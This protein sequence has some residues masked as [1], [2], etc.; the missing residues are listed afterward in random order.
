METTSC[1]LSGYE[2]GAQNTLHVIVF[3]KNLGGHLKSGH[4]WSLENR[5]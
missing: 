1:S 4:V 3:V 5:P 2:F